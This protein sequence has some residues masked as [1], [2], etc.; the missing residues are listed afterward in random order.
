MLR[1]IRRFAIGVAVTAV[2]AM[3]FGWLVDDDMKVVTALFGTVISF[4]VAFHKPGESGGGGDS[5]G[6]VW[7]ADSG[8]AERGTSSDGG[9]GSDGGG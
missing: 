4:F 1:W 8:T 6:A 3:L 9:G 7:A 5:G 2:A